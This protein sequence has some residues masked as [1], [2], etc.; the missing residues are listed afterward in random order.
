LNDKDGFNLGHRHMTISTSGIVPGILKFAYE[1]IQVNLAISLHASNNELRSKLMPVNKQF[2]LEKLLP[3]V[4]EYMGKTGR[5]VFF[6]YILLKDINDSK[7]ST[8]KLVHLMK[9]YFVNQMQLVHINLIEYNPVRANGRSP[10]QF[11]SPEKET[12]K[13]VSDTLQKNGVLTTIRYKFG[14]DIDAACGQLGACPPKVR[15]GNNRM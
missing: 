1:K 5:K 13:K 2:P 12:I 14:E 11:Q 10:L 15:T 8:E 7:E 4:S 6:E 3:A 9:R